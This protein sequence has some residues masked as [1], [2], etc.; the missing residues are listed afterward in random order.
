MS[1]VLS[2]IKKIIAGAKASYKFKRVGRR[3]SKKIAKSKKA[4][5]NR[6]GVKNAKAKGDGQG[7]QIVSVSHGRKHSKLSKSMEIKVRDA[8]NPMDTYII[9]GTEQNNSL[10]LGKCTYSVWELGSSNDI[11][12]LLDKAG[13][14]RGNGGRVRI[15]NCSME[16]EVTNQ[17]NNVLNLKVYEYVARKD[18]PSDINGLSVSTEWIVENGFGF[19]PVG[20][21]EADQHTLGATLYD[22]PLFCAYNKIVRVRNYMLGSGKTMKMSLNNDNDKYINPITYFN[23]DTETETRFTR[24]F[25]FQAY[26]SMVGAP[27]SVDDGKTTTGTTG[28]DV[29]YRMKYHYNQPDP[30]TGEVFVTDNVPKTVPGGLPVSMNPAT[31]TAQFQ[32]TA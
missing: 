3:A 15:S 7:N 23:V 32:N 16:L 25:V 19:R 11:D 18:L 24:G 29:F 28:Y 12:L 1:A 26:G 27:P 20:K 4:Y 21:G 9:Q 6:K 10:L 22:N 8:L 31:Q 17:S 5:A 30:A 14:A 13:I 2:A